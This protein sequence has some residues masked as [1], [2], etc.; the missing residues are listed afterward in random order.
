MGFDE[1]FS[2]TLANLN[3]AVMVVCL[4]CVVAQLFVAKKHTA[5]ILFALF[6]GSVAMS[7]AQKV[8]G[9]TLGAYQYLIGMGACATCNGYWL[10]SR[11]L[12]RRENP[13]SLHHIAVALVI[14]ALIL[15][16]QGYLLA[17]ELSLTDAAQQSVTTHLIAELTVLLSSCVIVLSFWEGVRGFSHASKTEQA[18]RVFF[19]TLFGLAVAISKVSQGLFATDP[20]SHA[21]VISSVILMVVLGTQGLLIW[22]FAEK[23]QPI[24]INQALDESSALP[25]GDSELLVSQQDSDLAQQVSLLLIE[26]ELFLQANLKVADIA[27]ALDVPEYRVSKALKHVLNAKNFNQYVN[28][29]RVNHAQTLLR[30]PNKQHW[31]VLVVSLESGFASVGPFTR[32]FKAQTGFTPNQYRQHQ[33]HDACA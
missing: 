9:D 26:K 12:F 27:R 11:S 23:S 13:I 4:I 2:M 20:T 25:E 19:L 17:S 30:D 29:L 5:H 33:M 21:M 15:S 32:A 7:L 16:K 14:S 22:R 31:S 3:T 8:A 1:V 10:L 24:A 28:E 6:C 18:Q